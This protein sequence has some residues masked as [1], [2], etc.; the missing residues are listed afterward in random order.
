[1]RRVEFINSG[2]EF[3]HGDVARRPR[4]LGG[5]YYCAQR[6]PPLSV[7]HVGKQ[8]N[9]FVANSPHCARHNEKSWHQPSES[10]KTRRPARFYSPRTISPVA[11]E[12]TA[13]RSL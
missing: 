7:W 12:P 13:A 2:Q 3:S 1:V 8:R 9:H 5:G 4:R 11:R 10:A 6:T